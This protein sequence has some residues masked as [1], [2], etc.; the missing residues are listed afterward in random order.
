MAKN[1]SDRVAIEGA[2]VARITPDT[3]W[4]VIGTRLVSVPRNQLGD[5]QIPRLGE[6]ARIVVPA[7]F[8]ARHKLVASG[9]LRS[10][11]PA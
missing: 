8:A 9:R 11:R 10:L 2:R 1:G 5:D 4:C 3:I 7:W 6:E